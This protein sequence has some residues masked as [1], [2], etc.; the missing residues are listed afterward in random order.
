MDDTAYQR[1]FTQPT[2]T[3]HRRYEALRAV[4]IDGRAQKEVAEEF[5]FQ[6]SSLRQLVYEFRQSC[7]AGR[8]STE[9]PF[10]ETSMSDVPS[11]ARTSTRR[12]RPSLIDGS[13]CFPARNRCV[14]E[15]ER[16]GSSYSCR[17]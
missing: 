17:C 9:S 3:Y 1:Y 11:P 14:S 10:F 2:Q 6:Y 8:A 7:D 13:C 16:R 4:I 15:P 12:N 5:G